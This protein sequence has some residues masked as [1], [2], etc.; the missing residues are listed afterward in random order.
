MPWFSKGS[1]ETGLGCKL[2]GLGR[3]LREPSPSVYAAPC[4]GVLLPASLLQS[5]FILSLVAMTNLHF[6]NE[7][8]EAWRGEETCPKSHCQRLVELGEKL[9]SA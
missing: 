8:T 7:E 1:V 2:R 3:S 5:C 6:T 9:R 4:T